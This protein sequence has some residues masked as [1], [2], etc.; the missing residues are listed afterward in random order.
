L[1][2]AADVLDDGQIGPVTVAAVGKVPANTLIEEVCDERLAFLQRLPTF[3][4][5]GK[6]WT[7]RVNDVRAK[8]KAMAA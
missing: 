7:A 1:Q 5:F 4:H 3:A 2:R 8:A 6:G